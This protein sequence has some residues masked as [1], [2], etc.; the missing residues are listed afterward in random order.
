MTP[1][2]P[3]MCLKTGRLLT[4]WFEYPEYTDTQLRQQAMDHFGIDEDPKGNIFTMPPEQADLMRKIQGF[5]G[6]KKRRRWKHTMS[7]Q[8]V[9]HRMN[10][11]TKMITALL[12]LTA[13][14]FCRTSRETGRDWVSL[15]AVPFSASS[16][17]PVFPSVAHH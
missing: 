5:V 11:A 1:I 14:R 9:H 17:W 15:A 13:R 16:Y 8:E 4:E 2:D 12:E 7:D 6:G 3:E 10:E